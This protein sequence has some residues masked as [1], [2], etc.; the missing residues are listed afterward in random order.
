MLVMDKL[1]AKSLPEADFYLFFDEQRDHCI[2]HLFEENQYEI[3]EGSEES[4]EIWDLRT[5]SLVQ[6]D[7]TFRPD[8]NRELYS[9][10]WHPITGDMVHRESW[11]RS[12]EPARIAHYERIQCPSPKPA[13]LYTLVSAEWKRAVESIEPDVHEFF[14]HK[15]NFRDGVVSDRFIFRH[16][17]VVRDFL[18]PHC[19]NSMAV[20]IARVCRD[21]VDAPEFDYAVPASKFAGRHW[22]ELR[23]RYRTHFF[24]SRAL[25]LRLVE[26]L[27]DHVVLVPIA[28]FP[29]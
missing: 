15:L 21:L 12:R 14:P 16:R 29:E 17:V 13:P 4:F 23:E 22:I 3:H 11:F 26:L 5:A 7:P 27:P 18:R 2:G 1:D 28:S 25:A 19:P 20:G 24:V 10:N 6:L 9:E 8:Q